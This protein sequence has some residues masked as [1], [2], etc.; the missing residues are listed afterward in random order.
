MIFT[1]I[2]MGFVRTPSRWVKTSEEYQT[3]R[4]PI[5][6]ELLD[7]NGFYDSLKLA[8]R[9]VERTA[10]DATIDHR[11]GSMV[12]ISRSDYELTGEC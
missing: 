7:G 3:A 1:G 8:Q 9:T 12:L 10:D 2:V 6:I 4:I 11:C 5:R